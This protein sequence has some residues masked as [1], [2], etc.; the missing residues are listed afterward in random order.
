LKQNVITVVIILVG[1]VYFLSYAAGLPRT[2]WRITGIAIA[3]PAFVGLM[4]ARFELG[5]AFSVKAKAS[6]LVTSGVYSR[7]RNPIYVFS[8]LVFLGLIIWT[9]KPLLLLVLVLLIPMQVMRS[10]KEAAVLTEKFGEEYLAY[11]RQTW[12]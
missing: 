11:K 7:I 5:R 6:V 8:S 10:R 3:L 9:G 2:P 1:A 12:F 4:V